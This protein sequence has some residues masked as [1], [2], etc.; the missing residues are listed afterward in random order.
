MWSLK[1]YAAFVILTKNIKNQD[2]LTKDCQ[3]YLEDC[4]NAWICWNCNERYNGFMPGVCAK[5]CA[6]QNNVKL[7]KIPRMFMNLE[8]KIYLKTFMETAF[9]LPYGKFVFEIHIFDVQINI[10]VTNMDGNSQCI[11]IDNTRYEKN[12]LDKI[13]SQFQTNSNTVIEFELGNTEFVFNS[14]SLDFSVGTRAFH[15]VQNLN[16]LEFSRVV[17]IFL[18]LKQEIIKIME[19][20]APKTYTIC[21]PDIENRYRMFF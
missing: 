8:Q 13:F 9:H 10:Y 14:I 18:F 19:S 1:Y 5:C 11:F 6:R 4:K 16:Q 7:P 12:G 21:V 2:I 20:G 3:K 17:C 15:Y